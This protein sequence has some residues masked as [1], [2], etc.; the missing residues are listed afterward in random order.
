VPLALIQ[1]LLA[2]LVAADMVGR[3]RVRWRA[4]YDTAVK[5]SSRPSLRP[6]AILVLASWLTDLD[7]SCPLSPPSPQVEHAAKHHQRRA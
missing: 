4:A 3:M 2:D 7:R 5:P 6:P 1:A